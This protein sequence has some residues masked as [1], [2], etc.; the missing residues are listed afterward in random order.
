MKGQM[1]IHKMVKQQCEKKA[2]MQAPA[3]LSEVSWLTDDMPETSKGQRT[4]WTPTKL[5]NLGDP[6]VSIPSLNIY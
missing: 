5:M 6:N 4:I 2:L 3:T 1:P